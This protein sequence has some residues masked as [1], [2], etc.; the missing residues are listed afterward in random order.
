M[1][2]L[3]TQPFIV[4]RQ[5]QTLITLVRDTY[6]YKSFLNKNLQ[7]TPNVNFVVQ[8]KLMLTYCK[9]NNIKNLTS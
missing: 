6:N 3:V 5:T 2:I 9:W 4:C 8:H 1:R 7:K